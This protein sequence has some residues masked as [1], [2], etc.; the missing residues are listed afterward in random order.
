MTAQLFHAFVHDALAAARAGTRSPA[1][2]GWLGEIRRLELARFSV[3][4]PRGARVLDFGAGAGDQALQLTEQGFEVDAVDLE[5]SSHRQKQVFPVRSYDGGVLPFPDAHFDA[6]MSSN[7]LEHVT[8]LSGTLRE[9]ARV[10]KPGGTMLHVMPSS[11]WRWWSTLAEF[12]AALR[13]AVWGTW[14][15]PTGEYASMPRWRW[16]VGQLAWVV[17]PCLFRPHG[18]GGSALSELWSFSRRAWSRA[19]T[20]RGYQVLRVEPLRLWYTGEALLGPRVSLTQ[21]T[22]MSR[23]LG[24]VTLLYVVRAPAARASP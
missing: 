19:F 18:E 12:V 16:T 14:R 10:L 24:S 6:V 22:K 23:W 5:T 9:L 13:N 21:R 17:R 2:P 1:F 15:G 7:V 8:D 3:F 11:V 4:L 20:A